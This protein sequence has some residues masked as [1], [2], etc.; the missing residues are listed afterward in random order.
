MEVKTLRDDQ[1]IYLLTRVAQLY[2]EQNATQ[3]TIAAGLNLS[4]PTVSRLLKEARDEGLV[5]IVIQSP[6]R[7]VTEL[8]AALMQAFPHLRAAR[9]IRTADPSGVERAAAAYLGHIVRDGDI[10][11]VAWG[12][13]MAGVAEHLQP[14]LLK[15]AT[16]VQLTGGIA[17]SGAEGSAHDVVLRF[18][19]AL[20]ASVYY[21]HVPAVVDGPH[22]RDA[23]LSNRETAHVLELGRKAHIA[24][25]GIGVPD[26]RSA[27]VQAGRLS[28]E[29][30]AALRAKGAAGDICS[31][32]FTAG[33]ALC[34]P[35]LDGRT[36]G[37][38]LEELTDR[39]YGIAVVHGTHKA[40]AVLGALRGRYCN[41]LVI[42]EATA[43]V[44][45]HH[46]Q[47]GQAN[48]E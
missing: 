8:E 11:G 5:Q 9:V 36:I 25:Y 18:G 1:R 41:V 30:L 24:V 6:F 7:F 23:L 33:G 20:G 47:E 2:Y 34:D 35:A 10:I 19:R 46:F 16:V 3:E 45:L 21:L 31:R 17:R 15:H 22:V 12:S 42:D 14:R 32:Y 44:V 43:Q 38:S 13:T 4:R 40:Q 27:L 26:E 48:H 29:D 28:T 39:E 37:P